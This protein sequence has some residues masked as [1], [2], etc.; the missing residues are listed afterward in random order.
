MLPVAGRVGTDTTIYNPVSHITGFN[1]ID[2]AITGN[3]AGWL[4]SLDHLVLPVLVLAI[5]PTSLVIRQSSAS[6]NQVM[7]AAYVTAARASGLPERM[8]LFRF[9]FKNAMMPTLTVLG[10]TFA[11]SLTGVVLIETIFSWPGIGLYLTSAIQSSDYPVIMAVTVLGAVAYVVV[12]LVVD[13]VQATL[14]PRVRLE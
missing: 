13:L 9:V 4:D 3:W 11:G 1:L 7:A 10:L 12:N 8:I 6:V 2:A 14:D 5:Y